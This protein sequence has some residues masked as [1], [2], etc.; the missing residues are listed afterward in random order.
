M[1]K[2]LDEANRRIIIL[3]RTETFSG[4]DDGLYHDANKKST[5]GDSVSS[6]LECLFLKQHNDILSDV[7]LFCLLM[8]PRKES[9]LKA[10]INL[11]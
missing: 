9:K 5:W 7:F 1:G 4:R 3:N 8:S 10:F 2:S 11:D 6:T